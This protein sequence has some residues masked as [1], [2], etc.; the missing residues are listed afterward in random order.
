MKSDEGFKATNGGSTNEHGGGRLI[1]RGDSG[2]VFVSRRRWRRE[3]SDLMVVE[4]DDGRVNPDG[5]QELFHDVAH[6]TRGTAEDDDGVLRYKPPDSRLRRLLLV[7][8]ET[9]AYD[10]GGGTHGGGT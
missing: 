4:F 8:G 6:A 3:G 5:S 7:Y 10:G 2:V 1:L 9:A